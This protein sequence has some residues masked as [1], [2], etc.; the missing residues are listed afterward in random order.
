MVHR[1]GDG[2]HQDRQPVAVERQHRQ[3][4]ED[5]EVRFDDTLGLV[6]VQRRHHHQPNAKGATHQAGAAD[7]AIGQG[8]HH[9]GAAAY[10]ER[11]K[12][13]VVPERQAE[14]E[15]GH[16]PDQGEHDAVGFAVVLDETGLG[17]HSLVLHVDGPG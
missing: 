16:Q 9:A 1:D 17:R 10:E 2:G 13:R 8:Q 14:G 7:D 3:Q 6:D 4:R 12:Q 15:E 11:L 5:T